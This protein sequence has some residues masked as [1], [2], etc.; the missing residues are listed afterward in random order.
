MQGLLLGGPVLSLV[1]LHL[2]LHRARSGQLSKVGT[3]VGIGDYL[4]IKS[5][6]HHI[7]ITMHFS[8]SVSRNRLMNY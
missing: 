5:I 4:G 8:L 3:R 1:W 7:I 2:F 6:K